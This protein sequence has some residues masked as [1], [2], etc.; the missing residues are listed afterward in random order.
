MANGTAGRFSDHKEKH[1]VTYMISTFG[2][3]IPIV[4]FLVFLNTKV[5]L[6]STDVEV[7]ASITAHLD[8][9]HQEL[10]RTVDSIYLLNLQDRIEKLIRAECQSPDLRTV[11]EPEIRSLIRNY[12]EISSVPYVRPSCAALQA[13]SAL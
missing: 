3:I 8:A 5:E 7:Q 9:N 6:Y 1:G 10:E 12:N 4:M 2:S 11:L 13:T